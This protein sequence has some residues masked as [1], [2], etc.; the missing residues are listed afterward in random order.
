MSSSLSC[1]RFEEVQLKMQKLIQET[2]TN[3]LLENKIPLS[4]SDKLARQV[5]DT[6]DIDHMCSIIEQGIQD[7]RFPKQRILDRAIVHMFEILFQAVNASPTAQSGVIKEEFFN[8]VPRGECLDLFLKLVKEYCMG[9]SEIEL[10]TKK[11]ESLVLLYQSDSAIDWEKVYVNKEFTVYLGEL[12]TLILNRLRK[13]QKPIPALENK[14]PLK[15]QPYRINL[16]LN[17]I[18]LMQDKLP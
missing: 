12:L 9:D 18:C 11:V 6:I 1:E 14:I 4:I 13:D 8:I 16:F 3:T 7:V 2:V 10:H 15:Y 17:K 5:A